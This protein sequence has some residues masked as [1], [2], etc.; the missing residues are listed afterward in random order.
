[1]TA[2]RAILVVGVLLLGA[3]LS[4]AMAGDDGHNGYAA[5]WRETHDAIYQLENRI[6]VLEADPEI[7]DGY[8]APII[9][10]TRAEI[11]RLRATLRRAEW[12]WTVPCCYS[13]PPV[14]IR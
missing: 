1:M 5:Y 8:R 9:T 11:L 12:R 7:D 13:R 3:S 6:A 10:A 14:Y 2:T 4:P